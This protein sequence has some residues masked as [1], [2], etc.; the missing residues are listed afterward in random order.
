MQPSSHQQSIRR[1]VVLPK[2]HSHARAMLPNFIRTST[3]VSESYD[4]QSLPT[5][6]PL[7][8]NGILILPQII[9]SIWSRRTPPYVES[10]YVYKVC[11]HRGSSEEGNSYKGC[12][13]LNT[14]ECSYEGN[15]KRSRCPSYPTLIVQVHPRNHLFECIPWHT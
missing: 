12:V 10:I 6:N 2:M 11:R 13:K 4:H 14:Q 9:G 5:C 15:P 3:K 8:V 7:L 1:V